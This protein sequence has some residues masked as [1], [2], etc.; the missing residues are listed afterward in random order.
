MT[1]LPDLTPDCE[2]C[3]ALCCMALAFD[4][5]DD[6][7]I[8]KPA[9]L[10]C[11]KLAGHACTIYDHLEAEGF[12]GC[13]RYTCHGAGQRV[14]QEVFDGATW[15]DTPELAGPMSEALRQMKSVHQ[16]L[17]LLA[18]AER[19]ELEDDDEE[20][21]QEIVAALSPEAGFTPETLAATAETLKRVPA[22]LASLRDYI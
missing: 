3:A 11:P 13:A 6:F 12:S 10:P 17:E 15:V 20:T 16:A 4:A 21:R 8:D 5:G 1:E 14:T 22:F 19:L 7:A 18:S 9:G 2:H